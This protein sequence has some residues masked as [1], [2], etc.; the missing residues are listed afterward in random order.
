MVRFQKSSNLMGEGSQETRAL[1]S[2][3]VCKEKADAWQQE[4]PGHA[5]EAAGS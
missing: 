2:E 1:A 3:K 5:E 4:C